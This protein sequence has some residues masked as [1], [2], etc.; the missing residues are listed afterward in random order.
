MAGE[1][2]GEDVVAEYLG[3]NPQLAQWVETFRSYC[4]SSKQ[5]VA[6]REFILRNM[7]AFPTIQPGVLSSSVDRLLS[8]SMVWA[9]HV[10]LGCSYPQ[11]VMDKIKD[12]G[13]GIVVA[14]PPTHKTTKDGILARGKRNAT[15]ETEADSCVK[16][17]KCG[18]TELDSR[19]PGKATVSQKSGPPPQAPTEHQPFFNRLYKAVAWKLVSAGGFGPNLDHF[20]ILRSCVE[21]CKETLTCVFVPLKDIAGLPA[22]RTQ[23]EGHVCEIRCQAVYM[24]TGYGRDESAARAMAS[25]EALKV[26]QGRKV[27]VKICRRRYKGKDVEDLMLLDEQPRSQGFPPALSYPFQDEQLEDES[28]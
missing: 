5:W 6:R 2:S 10:F 14:E 27:T 23:K 26:F 11:A 9:N 16:K 4:E 24:G 12:M 3:Q 1:R 17:A 25:K 22:G 21:S 7:E 28:S 8:L 20:E 18:P 19:P 15:A 13:E